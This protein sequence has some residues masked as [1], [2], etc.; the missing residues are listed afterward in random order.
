MNEMVSP[1]G[2]C[3]YLCLDIILRKGIIMLLIFVTLHNFINTIIFINMVVKI[4][5]CLK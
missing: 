5:T 2:N 1:S 3:P 4:A